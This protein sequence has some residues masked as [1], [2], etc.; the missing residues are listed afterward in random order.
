MGVTTVSAK[1]CRNGPR[2]GE[3]DT[4]WGARLPVNEGG[5]PRL[6]RL[7]PRK[8]CACATGQGAGAL[9]ARAPH[10]RQDAASVPHCVLRPGTPAAELTPG[11]R[12][13]PVCARPGPHPVPMV[14]EPPLGWPC[15][16]REILR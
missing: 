15:A 1:S 11:P 12:E 13:G 2:L 9:G 16:V 10:G 5:A 14:W 3:T 7:S 4:R 6:L 8:P